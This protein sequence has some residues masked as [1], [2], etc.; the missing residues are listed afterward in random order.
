MSI[1][2]KPE[3][4]AVSLFIVIFSAL[5][6][7]IVTVAFIRIMIQ[8]Q[9]QAT[10]N[11]LSKSA[12]DSANAGVE[13]AKRLIVKFQSP[14]GCNGVSSP[15][16]CSLLA[17]ALG[18]QGCKTIQ[19]SSIFPTLAADAAEVP[20]QQ[21]PHNPNDPDSR[22][23]QAYTCVK[24]KIDTPDYL[25]NITKNKSRL[26]HLRGAD[27][28]NQIKIEWFSQQDLQTASGGGSGSTT[29]VRLYGDRDHLSETQVPPPL[30]QATSTDWPS[31][32]PALIRAQLL[33]FGN[34]FNLS[35]FEKNDNSNRDDAS[36]FLYPA[37]S[38]LTTTSF[39]DDIRLSSVSDTLKLVKCDQTFSTNGGLGAYACTMT[40]TLPDVVNAA[41]NGGRKDAYLRLDEFYNAS[42]SVRVTLQNFNGASGTADT[43]DFKAVQPE[44]D[45]TGRANDLFRRVS[46]RIDLEASSIPNLQAAVDISGS[47]C[48]NFKVTDSDDGYID[49]SIC[50]R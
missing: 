19:K 2:N 13:D 22:F 45:S 11:D 32:R 35:D 33:Q 21:D 24:V 39:S 29:T 28:F 43:V 15:G 10:T 7:T 40:I 46:S 1:N 30:P 27:A 48:K 16:P 6:I 12:L 50:G 3:S 26:I 49:N 14:D 4:G 44:V 5:L 42:T 18:A 9:V 17:D 47:L 25:A 8:E 38:G 23:D 20:V 37:A 34:S 31:N 41:T 36:L